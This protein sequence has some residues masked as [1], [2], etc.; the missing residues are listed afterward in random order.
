MQILGE[1]CKKDNN[2]T[3]ILGDFRRFYLE[4]TK[5]SH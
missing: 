2:D 4:L 1:I 3:E 5:F